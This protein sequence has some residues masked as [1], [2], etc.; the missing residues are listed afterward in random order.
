MNL[1]DVEGVRGVPVPYRKS[2]SL[3][4]L[5]PQ[6]R[7]GFGL[8]GQVLGSSLSVIDPSP[9]VVI[10]IVTQFNRVARGA[11]RIHSKSGLKSPPPRH[12]LAAEIGDD[13][14]LCVVALHAAR[15]LFS[16]GSVP[17]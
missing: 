9:V 6:P 17:I 11:R 12:S 1:G 10:K 15:G 13:S 3:I 14:S 4:G 7:I 16:C 8:D 2:A 5:A